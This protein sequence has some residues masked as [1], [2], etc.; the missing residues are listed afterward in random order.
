MRA[1][2][3]TVKK[4]KKTFFLRSRTTSLEL[5]T[6]LF[7]TTSACPNFPPIARKK[8]CSQMRWPTKMKQSSY[9]LLGRAFD[10]LWL[11]WHVCFFKK[12]SFFHQK[13]VSKYFINGI[14]STSPRRK[15][16]KKRIKLKKWGLNV[17]KVRILRY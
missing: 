7:H 17:V 6:E 2:E 4:K 11:R 1:S 14:C 12:M 10:T 15:Y 16:S 3:I 5:L 9:T 8:E 13:H